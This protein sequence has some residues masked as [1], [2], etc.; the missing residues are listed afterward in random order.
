MS[1]GKEEIL[2]EVKCDVERRLEEKQS[3]VIHHGATTGHVRSS[4]NLACEVAS[5]SSLY[6]NYSQFDF[7]QMRSGAASPPLPTTTTT[8]TITSQQQHIVPSKSATNGGFS[9]FLKY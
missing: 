9:T 7:S 3:R 8:T 1:S 5:L 4:S 6:S 2:D